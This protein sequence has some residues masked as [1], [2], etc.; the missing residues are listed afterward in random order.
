MYKDTGN[1]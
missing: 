1:F